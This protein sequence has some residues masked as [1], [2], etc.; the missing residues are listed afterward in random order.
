MKPA[1]FSVAE[2]YSGLPFSLWFESQFQ[3]QLQ[4]SL[5]NGFSDNITFC[6]LKMTIPGLCQ[7][8]HL[9]SGIV[10]VSSSGNYFWWV[11]QKVLALD[12]ELVVDEM[13]SILSFVQRLLKLGTEIKA[14]YKLPKTKI[15]IKFILVYPLDKLSTVMDTL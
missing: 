4:I 9:K 3:A 6:L 2:L 15:S 13:C 5:V 11:F 7:L 8:E 14:S 1:G 12:H 10:F